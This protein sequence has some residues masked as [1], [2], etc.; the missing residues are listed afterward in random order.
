M[1]LH[2]DHDVF[3]DAVSWVARTIP[4]HPASVIFSGLRLIA[5]Q[6]GTLLLSA[7]DPDLTSHATIE[8]DVDQEGEVLVYGHLLSEWIR[9]APHQDV[10]IEDVNGRLQLTCGSAKV[11]MHLMPI[12][13]L[14]EFPDMPQKTGTIEGAELQQ[15]VSQVVSA[16]SNDDTLPLL[17]SVSIEIDGDHLS[18]LAT[19]RYRL[20]LREVQW[21]PEDPSYKNRILIRA[22]RL[23][24]I[25]KSLGSVGDVE[26]FIG[27]NSATGYVGFCSAGRQSLVHRIDGDYP[28]VRS[29]FPSS[30]AGHAIINRRDLLDALKRAR[31]VVQKNSAVS[32]KF[33]DGQVQLFAGQG[34]TA[35]TEEFLP[36]ALVGDPLT[37]AFNPTYLQDGLQALTTDSLRLSFTSPVKPAVL[38]GQQEGEDDDREDFKLLVMPIRTYG[39]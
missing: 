30:V 36:A 15:A 10:D 7:Y 4:A 5:R 38:T 18:L 2:V 21:T 1:K 13:Q 14:P 28:Q 23:S 8:A 24:D 17:V 32:L 9:T 19:D 22:S 31:V 20:A 3:A 27:D 6:D 25:A 35:Q 37:I 16:A 26:V 39:A 34:D 12:E 33:S 11:S 29:L